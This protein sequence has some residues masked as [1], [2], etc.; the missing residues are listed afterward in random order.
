MMHLV[1]GCGFAA[2]LALASIVAVAPGARAASAP[3]PI[4]QVKW[5]GS[6]HLYATSYNGNKLYVFAVTP[7]SVT[8]DTSISIG[9]PFSMVVVSE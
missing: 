6:N 1:R 8:E 5:D 3:T 7:T 2:T 9:S 4:N